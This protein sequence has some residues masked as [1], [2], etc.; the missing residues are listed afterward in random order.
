[1]YI[2]PYLTAMLEMMT[3][4]C[5]VEF[6]ELQPGQRKMVDGIIALGRYSEEEIFF[7]RSLT[8]A[9]CICGRGPRRL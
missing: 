3:D 9:Y 6:E 4:H 8:F 1:M 2:L 7:L 5:E